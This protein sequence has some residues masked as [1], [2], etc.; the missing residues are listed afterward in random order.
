MYK[1]KFR[2]KLKLALN[3]YKRLIILLAAFLITSLAIIG[4]YANSSGLTIPGIY[5]TDPMTLIIGLGGLLV[6]CIL[7]FLD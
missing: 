2:H 4:I 7:V 5:D 1:L 6:I 3:K